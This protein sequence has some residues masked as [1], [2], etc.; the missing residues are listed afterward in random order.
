MTLNNSV[1]AL[2]MLEITCLTTRLLSFSII[3]A[4]KRVKSKMNCNLS[5]MLIKT[6]WKVAWIQR[7]SLILLGKQ[8]GRCVLFTI[9]L[10]TKANRLPGWGKLKWHLTMLM[11]KFSTMEFNQTRTLLTLLGT[12]KGPLRLR[13]QVF[14]SII[15]LL[16][17]VS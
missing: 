13:F 17:E 10:R 16:K 3:L 6:T 4:R 12:D 14:Q 1:K 11:N 9:Q 2:L 5:S 8:K 15:S 7:V